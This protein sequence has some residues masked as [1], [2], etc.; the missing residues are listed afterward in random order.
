M[1][2]LG[3]LAGSVPWGVVLTR[4]FAPQV[5]LRGS[6]SGNIGATNVRRTAGWQLGL[7][8]LAADTAKG[9]LPV[10]IAKW[11]PLGESAV[12]LVA[13]AAFLGHLYPLY[14]GLKGGGK[15]VATLGG[16]LMVLSPLTLAVCLGGFLVVAATFRRVSAASLTAVT[17]MPLGIWG[18][19]A[20]A[21]LTLWAVAVMALVWYRHRS[22]IHRMLQGTEPRI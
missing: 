2:L 13:A 16:C 1:V 15:G 9:A 12:A 19:D 20:S 11:I 22:N 6:G 14:T 21:P 7:A 10:L 5:D 8:T 3:Y 17:L 18:F 4:A